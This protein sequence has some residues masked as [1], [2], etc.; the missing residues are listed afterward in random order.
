MIQTRHIAVRG[1]ARFKIQGLYRSERLKHYIEQ[2]LSEQEN[3]TRF[4]INTLTGSVLI[5]FNSGQTHA[6]IEAVLRE[7]L[8]EQKN[9]H[10]DSHPEGASEVLTVADKTL[11][12]RRKLRKSIVR[13]APQHEEPWHTLDASTLLEHFGADRDEGLPDCLCQ[14]R[15]KKFGPNVL[16]ESVPRSGFTIFINQFQSIPVGLLG[17][18]AVISAATGG[19]VDALVIA[20]VVCL[21]SVIGY[22]SE[23]G[24]EKTMHSLKTLVRPSA[25]VI[26][27]HKTREV[28][29]AHVVPGDLLLLRPG[30]YIAADARLLEAA[31]LSV[32]ESALTGESM[33]VHKTTLPISALNLPLAER[34]NMVY[35]GTLVTGGQG[36][37]LVIATGRFTEM[38][39][40][41]TMLSAAK[42]PETPM[43]R[44]LDEM[45]KQLVLISGAVCGLV[46]AIGILYGYNFLE[47]LKSAISLAVAAV[48]EG[49]PTVATTTL[50]LGIRKMREK[51]VLIRHLEAVETLGSVQTI[52]LDKTG[53][54]TMNKMAVREIYTGAHLF[55][56][57]DG[58]FHRNNE[59]ISPYISE[60]LLML[61]QTSVLCNESEL[62]HQNGKY[63]V[64][65]TPTENSFIHM[66]IET[67]IDVSEL[68]AR[69]PLIK[70]IHRSEKRNIMLTLHSELHGDARFIAVKGSP[71]EVLAICSRY[72]HKGEHLLLTDEERT[73]IELEN[74]NMAG[75]AYRILGL[76][77]RQHDSAFPNGMSEEQLF[78]DLT[79]LGLVSIADP[80][81]GGVKQLMGAFHQAGIDTVMIT[82]DQS[83][84]AYAVAKELDLSNHEQLEILD[85]RYLSDI[86][87]EILKALCRK[88][89]VFARV[90]PSHKLQIVKALQDAGRIVA[91]TGDG[92]ND[93][94]A[95][96]AA[97][98]GIAMGHTGT[99]VAREVAD[100][101]IEDDNLET[102][103][104]AVSHGRTIYNNI[105]KSIHFLLSTNMSEIMVMFTS[106]VFGLG[107]PLNAMQLLWINLMSD[108]FPGLALALEEPEPD[109]LNHPPRDPDEA[110]IEKDDLKRITFESAVISAGTLSAYG[111]GILRYGF[112]PQAG[113]IAFTSLTF[114]Q[115][116]HALSCR[117]ERASIF[118]GEK[119]PPNKYLNLA[120][121]GSFALQAVAMITPG[122]R[123]LLGITRLGLIDYAIVGATALIPL[124]VNEASKADLHAGPLPIQRLSLEL[125]ENGSIQ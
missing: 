114:A 13:S 69:C 47:M 117:S 28:S 74:E 43:E 112:G 37:A 50:A 14:E 83:P 95:L 98:I 25:L 108:I 67:G 73:L 31:H 59:L 10:F 42:P 121:G 53:T 58:K 2:Q 79:W 1:R 38:G 32:D 92:I 70:V 110:I 63:L 9:E 77:Y 5:L 11:S 48:P 68:R 81:R 52:C 41:Q 16:P 97:D 4:S 66:A 55:Q 71:R 80:V 22:L 76:A 115:L 56:V 100:V 107:Q 34:T 29:S 24:T 33:P 27:E 122:L 35:M 40:I 7:I 123:S 46:F 85:S 18:A 93:G 49:L 106:L 39:N 57:L 6:D 26:R 94:P 15:L 30:S 89:H 60:E 19:I 90:S 96:K 65:G 23:S 75:K 61:I 101:I 125:S 103:I 12:T 45:G 51:N 88:V 99:D 82:G 64:S 113:T 3:I 21:N 54:L 109:I 87:P 8:S 84:T 91:M 17:L 124:F 86:P 72:M 44:R 36:I 116:F 105:R 102:M 118:D 104:I 111:Y 20:S 119:L 62:I 78:Q 120:L